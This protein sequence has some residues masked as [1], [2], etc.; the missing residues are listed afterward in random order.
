M[1]LS[2]DEQI[3]INNQLKEK[4]EK[5]D[6]YE[7]MD[8][9]FDE[10]DDIDEND[11]YLKYSE[12][13]KV[14]SVKIDFKT[15]KDLFYKEQQLNK[16]EERIRYQTLDISNLNIQKE[17]LEEKINELEEENTSYKETMELIEKIIKF[18][19]KD[20][21]LFKLKNNMNLLELQENVTQIEIQFRKME[22]EYNEILNS[23]GNIENAELKRYLNT[24]TVKKYH[25]VL[26]EYEKRHQRINRLNLESKIINNVAII[27]TI[28]CMLYTAIV[29]GTR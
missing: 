13:K 23:I 18:V 19:N 26:F 8:N 3:K 15:L 22:K 28:F 4:I 29:Y 5:K 24:I 17:E 10:V 27:I 6:D 7:D 12:D 9:Y 11:L 20:I 21:N 1:A 14:K 16:F 25:D 2:K